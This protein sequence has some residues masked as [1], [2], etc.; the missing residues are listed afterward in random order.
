MLTFCVLGSGSSGNSAYISDGKTSILLDAGF[1]AKEILKRLSAAGLG[2]A[3]I[4]AIVVSHEHGDHARGSGVIAR[5]LGAPIYINRRT[6]EKAKNVIGEKVAI[7]YFENGDPFLVDSMRVEPFAIP[8]DAANP[9]AFIFHNE[10]RKLAHVTDIGYATDLLR[11][12]ISDAD[13][14]VVEANHEP[15]M[16]KAGPY[17]WPLK[18]RIAS[19]SGHLSNID[20]EKLLQNVF[21]SNLQGVTFA[22]LSETNNNPD[23]VAEI[24]K[25]TLGGVAYQVASQGRPGPLVVVE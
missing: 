10:N 23:L 1:S 9:S 12:K 4:D 19:R 18:Q 21:H 24:G 7:K 3:K 6:Y 5:K 8:H 13:Y 11:N 15:E 25:Q 17:P 2:G 22:H 16:L 14:L 20:C